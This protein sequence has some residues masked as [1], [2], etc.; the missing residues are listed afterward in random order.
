MPLKTLHGALGVLLALNSGVASAIFVTGSISFS[1]GFETTVAPPTGS[2]VSGLTS[3]DLEAV[4]AISGS[5][6]AFVGLNNPTGA[7]VSDFSFAGLPSAFYTAGTFSFEL[8][9]IANVDSTPLSCNAQGLCNDAL[10]FD[11]A[12]SV[13][14]PGFD[15]T[16]FLGSWSANGSCLG[17]GTTCQSNVTA[18]WS[19][20]ISAV[21][22]EAPPPP[23][24]VPEPST[25]ALMG[26]ILAGLAVATKRRA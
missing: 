17:A 18:S 7:G 21:G 8:F 13:S 5:N 20:S 11:V 3:F 24:S 26:L 22:R 1:D 2:I 12:G 14:G 25:L 9:T 16:L 15:P 10:T 4:G 6:G 19:S 23:P